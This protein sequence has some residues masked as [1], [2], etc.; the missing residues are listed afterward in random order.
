M[1]DNKSRSIQR[2]MA[3]QR[4]QP[5]PDFSSEA[6]ESKGFCPH[7][8]YPLPCDKCGYGLKEAIFSQIR[9]AIGGVELTQE[10]YNSAERAG[11]QRAL[12]WSKEHSI[13]SDW[14]FVVKRQRF[15]ME[16]VAKVVRQSILKLLGGE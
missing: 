15:V 1:I 10:E 14:E 5:M 2:R 7:H 8:G 16:E 12:K 11:F 3:V 6:E 9:Q 4:G 13:K